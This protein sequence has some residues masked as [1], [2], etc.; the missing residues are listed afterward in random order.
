MSIRN[1]LMGDV[2][3]RVC[4]YGRPWWIWVAERSGFLCVNLMEIRAYFLLLTAT[5]R[6]TGLDFLSGRWHNMWH[7]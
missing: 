2:H 1:V 7:S 4:F 6:S 3:C 5:H